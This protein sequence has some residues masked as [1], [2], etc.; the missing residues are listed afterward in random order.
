MLAYRVREHNDKPTQ[1]VVTNK[2]KYNKTNDRGATKASSFQEPPVE[3][4]VNLV[5]TEVNYARSNPPECIRLPRVRA[6]RDFFLRKSGVRVMMRKNCDEHTPT[7]LLLC[8]YTLVV[9]T[10]VVV[11]PIRMIELF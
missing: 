11:R 9:A 7:V 1:T 3:Y 4:Q 6:R 5:P 10:E 2:I 8:R